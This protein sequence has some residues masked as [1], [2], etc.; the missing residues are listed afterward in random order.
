LSGNF[1]VEEV[2]ESIRRVR[3][4]G[5]EVLTDPPIIARIRAEE[6]LLRG[7]FS[8]EYDDYCTRTLRL[9]PAVY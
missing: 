6:A 1:A 2:K 3:D 5:R 8:A 7:K 9:L 4:A